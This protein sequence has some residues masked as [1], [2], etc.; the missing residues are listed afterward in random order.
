MRSLAEGY[1]P[2]I[3]DGVHVLG[4]PGSDLRPVTGLGQLPSSMP[5]TRPMSGMGSWFDDLKNW[6]SGGVSSTANAIW[7]QVEKQ[8]S[9]EQYMGIRGI[10]SGEYE[11]KLT[12]DRERLRENQRILNEWKSRISSSAEQAAYDKAYQ[13]QVAYEKGVLD[14]IS[15]YNDGIWRMKSSAA[16][17]KV[18]EYAPYLGL[19]NPQMLGMGV[20]PVV[21]IA[22]AAAIVALCLAFS[23]AVVGTYVAVDAIYGKEFT[24]TPDGQ[25]IVHTP[26]HQ[27]MSNT[28]MYVAIGVAVF[29]G[30]K[31]IMQSG[32]LKGVSEI[33]KDWG[34][35]IKSAGKDL[36]ASFKGGGK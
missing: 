17:A 2:G 26:W 16:F 25:V 14:A 31:L 3:A 8:L 30:A 23:V 13:K 9:K 36:A 10:L 24:V 33:G 34:R 12:R 19:R 7:A 29:F 28:A 27:S 11:E 5:L 20:L 1:V 15:T 35:G 6:I 4:Y 21:A 32:G 22:A 18:M